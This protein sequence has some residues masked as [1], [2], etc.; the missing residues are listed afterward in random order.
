MKQQRK[1]QFTKHLAWHLKGKK[2]QITGQ[3][4]RTGELSLEFPPLPS[5]NQEFFP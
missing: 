1:C 4:L 3:V 5:H 2:G